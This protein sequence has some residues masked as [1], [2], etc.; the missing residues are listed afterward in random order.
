MRRQPPRH[1]GGF[2]NLVKLGPGE[3][4]PGGLAA[5]HG[6]V[7]RL[8]PRDFAALTNMEH[9]Y[10]WAAPPQPPALLMPMPHG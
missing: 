5:V 9:E 10:W 1:R 4:G 8:K 7:H 6:V 3:A 2:G